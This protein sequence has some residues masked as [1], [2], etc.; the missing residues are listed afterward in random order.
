MKKFFYYLLLLPAIIFASCNDD[1]HHHVITLNKAVTDFIE[2]KYPGAVI[3]ET[4]LVANGLIEVDVVH[5]SK[6]K[7]IYFTT[8][9]EWVRTEW[10]VVPSTLSQEVLGSIATAYP[11]YRLDDV[12]YVQAPAGDYYEVNV[13]KGN[14]EK[15]L[16]VSLDGTIIG[17][18]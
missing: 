14:F 15:H 6:K 18:F 8:A 5:D 13:E 10:D 7:E 17:E 11:D 3:T 2:T 4:E 16:K 9:D 12:D 1:D